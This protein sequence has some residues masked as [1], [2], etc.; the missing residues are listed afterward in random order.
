M[1]SDLVGSGGR[2]RADTVSVLAQ[3]PTEKSRRAVRKNA[4][5]SNVRLAQGGDMEN[6]PIHTFAKNK[7]LEG[8]RPERFKKRCV[9]TQMRKEPF[10]SLALFQSVRPPC[11]TLYSISTYHLLLS[12][13]SSYC[14]ALRCD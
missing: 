7:D 3:T 12:S 11:G 5:E 4:S 13:H 8:E 2:A 6:L 14:G 1:A 9:R 10:I